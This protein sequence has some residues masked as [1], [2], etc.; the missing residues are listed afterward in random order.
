MAQHIHI[1]V[2]LLERASALLIRHLKEQAG[3][4]V[5]LDHDYYWSVPAT[6]V[7]DVYQAPKDLTI[8]QITECMEWLGA[9]VEDPERALVYHLVWLADVLRAVG[10]TI[11]E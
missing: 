10:E 6:Q 7:Y 1:D 11:A 3:A 8:G 9:V 2:D 5:L 4:E